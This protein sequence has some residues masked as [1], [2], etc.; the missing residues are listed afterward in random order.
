MSPDSIVLGAAGFIGRSLVAELLDRGDHVAAALRSGSAARLTDWLDERGADRTRLTV[1]TCDITRPGLGLPA[2][3]EEVR[4]VYNSAAAFAWGLTAETAQRVNVTGALHV[5]D[6]AASRPALRRLVHITG[7]RAALKDNSATGGYESSKLEADTALTARAVA[8]GVPLTIANPSSVIGPGQYIGLADIV[9]DLWRGR[10]PALPGG[11]DTFVPVVTVDY[12]A[13]FLASL[14][15]RAETAGRSYTVLDD[16]T[17]NLPDLVRMLAAHLG[18]PAPRFQVPVG[19]VRR[20]PR[21]LTG[22]EPET[23]TF[24]SDDRYDTTAADAHARVVG[25]RMPPVEE[26]LRDWADHL[27][28]SRFGAVPGGGAGGFHDGM[29]VTGDREEPGQVLLHGVPVDGDSWADV[30]G[31]LGS[32]PLRADLPGLGRSAPDAGRKRS[33]P[34]PGGETSGRGRSAPGTVGD[35]SGPEGSA[36]R[37][38]SDVAGRR[39]AEGPPEWLVELMRPVRTRPVLVA[40]SLSCDPAIRFALAYPER[41]SK[42]VLVAPAFL[43]ARAGRLAR[44]GLAAALL[45]RMSTARLATVLGV[46]DGPAVAGAAANLRRPGVARRTVA[47][48]RAASEPGRRAAARQLLRQ[49]TVPVEIIVGERDPL[50]DYAGW[51]VSVV[52]GAGHYPQ[53]S[54]PAE[55]ARL[56]RAAGARHTGAV[57]VP[58]GVA[59]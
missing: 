52:A 22:V 33:T 6:W 34:G 38:D 39:S 19:L 56:V 3:L 16:A 57:E 59:R 36:P 25:L 41:I 4:D 20:L 10:L 28:G 47:A 17:P 46:P 58:D 2:G 37:T 50:V 5:L 7:Y 30:A 40:H 15:G 13:R 53:I 45:R 48:L 23:L 11:R 44:S 51:P 29:W 55:V 24:L 32:R 31:A 54:H 9:A 43:Q 42:L 49:V 14:P 21:A 35:Q 27:V 26:A 18:V 12:F 1:V 8:T